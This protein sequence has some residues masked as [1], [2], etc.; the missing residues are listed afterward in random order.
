MIERHFTLD[1]TWKGSDHGCSLTPCDLSELVKAIREVE[2]DL[3]P[4][5]AA[6]PALGSFEKTV[7]DS[8]AACIA[9][10]GKTLVAEHHLTEGTIL[11]AQDVSVKV[12]EPKGIPCKH[13]DSVLGRVLLRDVAAD[14]SIFWDDLDPI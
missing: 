12:A 8:E 14:E 9:K 1:K 10:L 11:T 7:Q 3:N 13:Y 6:S 2:G 4:Q 5:I